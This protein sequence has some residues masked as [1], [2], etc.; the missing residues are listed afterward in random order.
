MAGGWKKLTFVAFI[1]LLAI[2][3][4]W[5][6]VETAGKICFKQSRSFK[7]KCI[8]NDECVKACDTD[9]WYDGFCS[10]GL[11]ICTVIC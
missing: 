4:G 10:N 6:M 3:S 7:G 5:M 1:F 9:M 11:C 8:S 2:A